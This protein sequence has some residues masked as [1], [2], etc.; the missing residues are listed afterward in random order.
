MAQRDEFGLY[1]FET[2]SSSIDTLS[3]PDNIKPEGDQDTYTNP[4]GNPFRGQPSR[5][6][7]L[8]PDYR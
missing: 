1:D 7:T 8:R 5:A 3:D 4:I 6:Q 2:E